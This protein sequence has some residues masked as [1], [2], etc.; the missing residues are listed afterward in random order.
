MKVGGKFYLAAQT[1]QRR[2]AYSRQMNRRAVENQQAA[3]QHFGQALFSAKVANGQEQARLALQVAAKR[4]S[5]EMQTRI[6]A[7]EQTAAQAN[8]I[9]RERSSGVNILA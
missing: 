6:K 1:Q 9:A 8:E 4:M 3:I 7:M 2:G 5:T